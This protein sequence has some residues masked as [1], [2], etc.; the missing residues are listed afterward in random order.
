MLSCA[1]DRLQR[2]ALGRRSGGV[3]NSDDSSPPSGPTL[4]T[5]LQRM[6]TILDGRSIRY[7]VIGGIATIQHG[8]VRTTN[9]IDVIISVPQIGMPGL[10]EALQAA[11]FTVDVRANTV[12]LRDDGLT[13]IQFADV[14]LDLMR[15]VLPIY[16]H[17]LDRAIPTDLFGQLVR[18]SSAECLIVTKLVAFRPQDQADIKDL[19]A[20]YGN[21]L[22]FAFIEAEFA[23][24]FET[25]DP[26]WK[27]F[28]EWQKES[29]T[30]INP[31]R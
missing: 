9:D 21:L 23:S 8:R 19:L 24:V 22:D 30:G 15:P 16:A 4:K 20:A 10:F 26:R 31:S 5:A 28:Q 17:V 13:T 2:P 25:D 14:L 3:S 29:G 6:V 18:I 11:G 7:A 1:A 12:E 27:T